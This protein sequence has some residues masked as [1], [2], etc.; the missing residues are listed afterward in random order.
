MFLTADDQAW[1]YA[2]GKQ[3]GN[4]NRKF[5]KAERYIIPQ[6]SRQLAIYVKNTGGPTGL[7]AKLSNGLV[8]DTKW[9]VSYYI[10][11]F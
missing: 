4:D 6:G 10:F 3:L 9:R 2:D 5:N 11:S 7:A 1:V 8:T